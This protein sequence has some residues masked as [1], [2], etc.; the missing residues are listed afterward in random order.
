MNSSILISLRP[1]ITSQ[2]PSNSQGRSS[3]SDEVIENVV[4]APQ[5]KSVS[6][7]RSMRRMRAEEPFSH[8]PFKGDEK[9]L[10]E[11]SVGGLEKQNGYE[12]LLRLLDENYFQRDECKAEADELVFL[13]DR[14]ANDRLAMF[15]AGL[16]NRPEEGIEIS[17]RG[18]QSFHRF[19]QLLCDPK[20]QL[21]TE[22][23]KISAPGEGEA[24]LLILTSL[25]G[26]F[27]GKSKL[28]KGLNLLVMNDLEGAKEAFTATGSRPDLTFDL[29]LLLKILERRLGVP[30]LSNQPFDKVSGNQRA[31][32]LFRGGDYEGA[33][34]E[35]EARK[36]DRFNPFEEY[37]REIWV[38]S[39]AFLG[40]AEES[41]GIWLE[42]PLMC[43]ISGDES[44]TKE[45]LNRIPASY[46]NL[47]T[48]APFL[49]LMK[50]VGQ[51]DSI[52]A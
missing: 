31:L 42:Q 11:I 36:N 23:E 5:T 41:M 39:S 1:S 3:F 27:E 25:A 16:A 40:K 30:F 43:Y 52:T 48:L 19:A 32:W 28:A 17:A 8:P 21:E 20:D 24:M 22:R 2:A 45:I 38:F 15:Y 18:I 35:I 50:A 9:W 34:K 37:D 7:G 46:K 49:L 10:A 13:F 33:L 26:H 12:R 29:I 51:F 6:L 44:R 47:E 4:T 14:I